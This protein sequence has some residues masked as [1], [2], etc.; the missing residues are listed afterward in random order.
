[1]KD[2]LVQSK[3]NSQGDVKSTR[4]LLSANVDTYCQ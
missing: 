4:H 2:E 3:I 1:M